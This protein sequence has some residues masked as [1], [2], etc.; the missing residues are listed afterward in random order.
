MN[1]NIMYVRVWGQLI[2]ISQINFVQIDP[3][4]KNK[5]TQEVPLEDVIEKLVKNN[6]NNFVQVK[7]D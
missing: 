1:K 5:I 4:N 6:M 3:N 7:N 2:S